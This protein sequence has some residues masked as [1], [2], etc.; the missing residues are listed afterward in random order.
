LAVSPSQKF[1][2]VCEQA[3]KAI[4]TIYDIT[5]AQ[6]PKRRKTLVSYDYSSTRFVSVAFSPHNEKSH[7]LTLVSITNL[8]L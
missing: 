7:L 3:D 1:L 2:A 5:N 8:N 6:Q 4:C